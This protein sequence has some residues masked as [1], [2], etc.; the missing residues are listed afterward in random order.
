MAE[1]NDEDGGENLTTWN[2]LSECIA[3]LAYDRGAG[4]AIFTFVK[5][6]G[7]QYT[8]P[9]SLQQ[10]TAWAFSPSPGEYFNE[11]IK[12]TFGF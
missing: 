8:A 7:K 9:M 12:G 1:E 3:S 10:A 4:V 5:G 11:K 2:V 6:G